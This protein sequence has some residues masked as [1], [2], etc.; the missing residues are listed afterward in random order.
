MAVNQKAIKVLGKILDAGFTSEKD[1][2]AMTM[3]DI[4]AL[5]GITLAD[6]AI[7]NYLQKSVKSNKVIAFL[8]GGEI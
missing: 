3:D 1:I 5:P 8:G 6:I 4:L 7:I 2:V